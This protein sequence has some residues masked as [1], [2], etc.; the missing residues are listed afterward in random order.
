MSTILKAQQQTAI[1][2]YKK[3]NFYPVTQTTH[4]IFQHNHSLRN[5]KCT[6]LDHHAM[7]FLNID[8]PEKH[9]LQDFIREEDWNSIRDQISFFQQ[10]KNSL[11]ILTLFYHLKIKGYADNH[12]MVATTAE[13]DVDLMELKCCTRLINQAEISNMM[14]SS[15]MNEKSDFLAAPKSIEKLTLREREICNLL[16]EGKIVK[17]I[18]DQLCRSSRTIEQ[19]KKNIYKKL[20]INSLN[21][22]Y[23]LA[24]FSE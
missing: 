15:I 21:G 18:A 20:A 23:Q 24:Y 17:E 3:D 10:K 1:A 16:M 19:H 12:P 5:L 8:Q 13:V 6:F 7:S 11:N 2:G 22:L 4:I 9:Y 14:H